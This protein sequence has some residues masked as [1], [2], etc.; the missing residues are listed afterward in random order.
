MINTPG[1]PSGKVFTEKEL[2]TIAEVAVRFNLFIFTDEIY[3][4]FTYDRRK[5]ISPGSI[6]AIRDRTI[7]IGGYSKTYSI[8]GWR[9]GYCIC[10][11]KLKEAIGF[12]SDLIYVC[13]PAPLQKG[14]SDGI[15]FISDTYY[16][17]L[18]KLFEEKRDRL[19]SALEKAKLSS[20]IHQGAYYILA[21]VSNI[22]GKTCK[23]KALYLL[24]KSGVASVPG[25]AF[26][27]DNS[28]DNLVRFCFA[29]DE[30]NLSEAIKRL[31]KF[32]T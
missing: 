21:D 10:H 26:Y 6:P 32:S 22:P 15:N 19:C 12:M 24:R 2:N 7:T 4:Y 1:N 28:G 13:A 20:I 23:E 9:I 30:E 25:S 14:V 18:C 31:L 3:E 27:H 11:E 16:Q 5:H 17:K 8:T 29:V